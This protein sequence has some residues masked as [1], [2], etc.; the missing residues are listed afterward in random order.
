MNWKS[1]TK[2]NDR[3]FLLL[4]FSPRTMAIAHS[5]QQ[6]S[7]PPS[8][9]PSEMMQPHQNSKV[10]ST[11]EQE[12]IENHLN[13]LSRTL[14][15][16]LNQS[17]ESI[18]KCVEDIDLNLTTSNIFKVLQAIRFL[19]QITDKP[20]VKPEFQKDYLDAL[21]YNV[22]QYIDMNA[23]EVLKK[24]DIGCL[25]YVEVEMI[26]KRN[27]IMTSEVGVYNFLSEWSRLK[28]NEK[29]WDLTFENRRKVLG[30]L[31]FAPR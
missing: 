19:A 10:S 28:C 31:C 21:F 26:V 9:P 27:H 29:L 20:I 4:S 17:L 30:S 6:P 14:S 12:D 11:T 8:A 3:F 25:S 7:P 5:I 15:N 18:R 16:E 24:G 23:E 2:K 22:M 1:V 13:E